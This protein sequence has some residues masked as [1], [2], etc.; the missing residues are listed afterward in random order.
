MDGFEFVLF[1][2]S[3]VWEKMAQGFR[4]GIF[5]CDFEACLVV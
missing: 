4:D 3:E 1:S 5:R 2:K